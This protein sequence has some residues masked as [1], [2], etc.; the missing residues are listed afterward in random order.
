V[1]PL[2]FKNGAHG[3]K[4][5][6]V[7]S[8]FWGDTGKGCGVASKHDQNGRWGHEDYGSKTSFEPMTLKSENRHNLSGDG[9][10]PQTTDHIIRYEG[11]I[12][13]VG[14]FCNLLAAHCRASLPLK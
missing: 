9:G 2:R 13:F 14:F 11:L 1:N 7:I 5:A 8:A 10:E 3:N 4:P 6:I 12:A